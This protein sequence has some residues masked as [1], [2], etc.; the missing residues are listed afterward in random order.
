M[1]LP[2]MARH[3]LTILPMLAAAGLMLSACAGD[4]AAPRAAQRVSQQRVS[5]FVPTAAQ[6]EL[7]GIGD[8][9]YSITFD[10]TQDNAFV[11]G[12]NYLSLPANAVCKLDGSQ[13]YGP[14]YWNQSCDTET[15]S[16]TI[17]VTITD[18]ATDHPRLDFYPAMRFNPATNV[19][20]YIYVPVGLENFAKTWNMQYCNE[21][22]ACTNEALHDADLATFVDTNSQMVFRR[23]KHFSGYLVT[24]GFTDDGGDVPPGGD[25]PPPSDGFAP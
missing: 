19:S 14:E 8:G 21:T 20:L 5:P 15:D 6:K 1:R 12:A 16:V 17:S 22:G 7:I 2:T 4:V 18:A 25:A 24:N 9:Q 23:I 13:G 10:P 11:L 3:R